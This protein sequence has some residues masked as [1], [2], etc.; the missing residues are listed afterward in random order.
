MTKVFLMITI[1]Y[2]G[3]Q[4]NK[5][6]HVLMKNEADCHAT[7]LWLKRDAPPAGDGVEKYFIGCSFERPKEGEE[8]PS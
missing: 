7:E 6:Y 4:P 8:N 5:N 2:L 3:P 1:V